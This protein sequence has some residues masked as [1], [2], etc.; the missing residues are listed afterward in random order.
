LFQVAPQ[1]LFDVFVV[2]IA[3]LRATQDLDDMKTIGAAYNIGCITDADPLD[4]F[5]KLSAY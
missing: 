2:V 5:A 3:R 4:R 1:Y